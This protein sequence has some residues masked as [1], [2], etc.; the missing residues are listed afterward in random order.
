L[1]RGLKLEAE[2]KEH[3]AKLAQ[4]DAL[5]EL[6]QR[7]ISIQQLREVFRDSE[8]KSLEDQNRQFQNT[9]QGAQFIFQGLSLV[10]NQQHASLQDHNRRNMQ[11][12][13][14][15]GLNLPTIDIANVNHN[16][17]LLQS[18][19]QLIHQDETPPQGSP[20]TQTPPETPKTL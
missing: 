20:L 1:Q 3:Q 9:V 7:E 17:L 8:V 11:I 10:L 4:R 16:Q 2:Q 15:F 12:N 19:A 14:E 13:N 18:V 5:D 6:E